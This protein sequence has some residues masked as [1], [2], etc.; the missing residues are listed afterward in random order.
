MKKQSTKNDADAEQIIKDV[1]S[2]EHQDEVMLNPE[3]IQEA[4]RNQDIQEGNKKSQKNAEQEAKYGDSSDP[5]K[6][7]KGN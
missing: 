3:D 4:N 1:R 5:E 2:V 6:A 7:K